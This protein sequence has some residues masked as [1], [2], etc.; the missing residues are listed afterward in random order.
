MKK[1]KPKTKH[2]KRTRVHEIQKEKELKFF[3]HE[4]PILDRPIQN[5]L[6]DL[7]E[8]LSVCTPIQQLMIFETLAS[9]LAGA[10]NEE[11]DNAEV[12]DLPNGKTSVGTSEG[13]ATRLTRI[14]KN[15]IKEAQRGIDKIDMVDNDIKNM[16]TDEL[17]KVA[18]DIINDMKSDDK[19]KEINDEHLDLL[20]PQEVGKA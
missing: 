8:I 17:K 10:K 1:I 19:R 15:I 6:R 12:K 7:G 3:S 2:I 20:T 14:L 4:H 5:A 16:D 9:A 11:W 13:R 18:K